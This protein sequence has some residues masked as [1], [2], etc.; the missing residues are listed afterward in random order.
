MII[1]TQSVELIDEL[2]PQDVIVVE[3][4]EGASTFRRCDPDALAMWLEEYSLGDI[5]NRN[6]MGGRP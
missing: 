2:S 4:E 6:I 5:W 1:S 3:Q